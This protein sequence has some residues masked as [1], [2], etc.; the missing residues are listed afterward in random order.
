MAEI[1][2][3]AD[4]WVYNPAKGCFLEQRFKGGK[5]DSY[6][7][8]SSHPT[9]NHALKFYLRINL[10]QVNN[11]AAYKDADKNSFPIKT[12]SSDEW[13]KFTRGFE[14][15]SRLWNNRFWLIPP[16]SFSLLD[17]NSGGSKMRPNIQCFLFT[18]IANVSN[19]H[20]TIEVVNLDVDQ[21]KQQKGINHPKSGT[22]RSKDTLYDSLDVMPG[23]R[24]Y[25]D[26]QGDQ[27]RTN[28]HYVI[29]HEIGH[30]IGLPHV[31]VLRS[32]PQCTFAIALKDLGVKNVSSHLKGGSNAKVCYG[33]FDSLGLADN[34][35]GLGEKF[36]DINAKPWIERVAM[37]T[38]TLPKD[39]KV[40][41][42]RI[43]PKAA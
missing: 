24:R 43:Q 31:G 27:H 36:E 15:Q 19:A 11:L 17:A 10:R 21:I 42:S 14:E 9:Q 28:N 32:R 8:I 33:R 34:I 4:A 13:N 29:A 3:D 40:S 16:K 23:G 2:K 30:A 22:F 20:R 35:M 37:H 1:W 38:N 6:F 41:L 12:W 7:G 26:D 39:W 18:E 5:F 25:T